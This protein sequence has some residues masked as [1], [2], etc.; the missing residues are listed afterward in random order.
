MFRL[1]VITNP[2]S[3]SDNRND[4]RN[5]ISETLTSEM[6]KE[7]KC[8]VFASKCEK[9]PSKILNSYRIMTR[10]SEKFSGF[11]IRKVLRICGFV[12][13]KGFFFG[14]VMRKVCFFILICYPKSISDSLSEKKNRI[15]Y[16]T[17]SYP[18]I[19]L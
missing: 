1:R 6:S 7:L 13:R 10:V 12:V 11:V 18:I 3:F 2:K 16:G 14:F 4:I 8:K 15:C 19:I 17:S 9:V 5:M